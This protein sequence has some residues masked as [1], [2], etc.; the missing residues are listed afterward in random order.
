[1]ETR[2]AATQV[3]AERR[4]LA[5]EG[6]NVPGPDLWDFLLILVARKRLIAW[7]AVAG[8]LLAAGMA[9]QKGDM[10]TATAVIMLPQQQRSTLASLMGPLSPVGTA[11]GGGNDL[12]RTPSDQYL[13]L[14][15]SRSIADDLIE[16][17][18]LQR[19]YRTKNMTDT[20][21]KLAA[22][23]H[24]TAGKDSLIR[25]AVDAEG[26]QFAADLANAYVDRLHKLNSRL[27][28]TESAQRRQFFEQCL[29][30]ERKAVAD[31]EA[32][33]KA[34]QERTGLIQVSSQMD[35]AVRT[36]AQLRAE[37]T[38]REVLLDTLKS[39]ATDKNPEVVRLRVE[40]ESLRAQLASAEAGG[41]AKQ[42]GPGNAPAAGLAYMRA[43]REFQY[44]E[45]LFESLGKQYEAARLDEAKEAPL[46][47][48]V[49]RATP[50]E[51]LNPKNRAW[52]VLFGTL[53]FGLFGACLA[54]ALHYLE[55]PD[56]AARLRE[57]RTAMWRGGAKA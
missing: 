48:V 29:Q 47:Q 30:T 57:V 12:L 17:F 39:G 46:V 36:I 49:D 18:Q 11:V 3:R 2:V 23:T 26:A 4:T 44:H 55:T 31:A 53:S 50:P 51:E 24:L 10:Y 25:I 52:M 8:A 19:E 7:M 22:R 43:L 9:L 38:V 16:A 56:R 1:M 37:I 5:I 32:A 41:R 14:L 45:T 21:R 20:R 34:T 35:V 28:L 33:M 40:V 6:F 27:A 15:A 13:S 54:I 42:I